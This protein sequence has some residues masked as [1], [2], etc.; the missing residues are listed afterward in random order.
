MNYNEEFMAQRS[1]AIA[2]EVFM[3]LPER[4]ILLILFA[5]RAYLFLTFNALTTLN[6]HNVRD[7]LARVDT[8]LK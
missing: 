1:N 7:G 4:N 2:E 8:F 3:K 5:I 6:R